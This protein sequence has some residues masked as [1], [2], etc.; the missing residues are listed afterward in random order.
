MPAREL[1]QVA[2]RVVA[3]DGNVCTLALRDA[4]KKIL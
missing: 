4:S 3:H 2:D 1:V